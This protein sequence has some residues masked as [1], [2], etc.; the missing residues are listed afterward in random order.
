MNKSFWLGLG[1]IVSQVIGIMIYLLSTLN[2][3]WR[4]IKLVNIIMLIIAYIMFNIT[5]L[6]LIL[7]GIKS[8]EVK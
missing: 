6:T 1:M 4:T 8:E 7:R 3:S 2:F 5:A